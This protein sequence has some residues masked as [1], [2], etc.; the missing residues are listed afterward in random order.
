MKKLLAAALAVATMSATSAVA[1]PVFY[2][3]RAAFEAAA[4]GLAGFEGFNDVRNPAPSHAYPGFTIGETG[5]FDSV[6]TTG[7]NSFFSAA[8]TEGSGSVWY[9]DNGDSLSTFTFDAAITAFGI[10][11]AAAAGG[12]MT[13]SGFSGGS[14]GFDL[15]AE[16]PAF[17][18]VIDTTAFSSVTFD[19]EAGP[20]VGFDALA[21]GTAGVV[22][23]PAT[24]ALMI[25]GM[26]L[27]GSAL[28][29]RAL[30]SA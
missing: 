17:F 16:Q 8:T 7:A 9:D 2:T 29:R 20:E 24:W 25:G 15:A 10:D 22:P 1:A 14:F 30:A 11:V 12:L 23:E 28:R 27:I 3:D 4:G 21:F 6:V 5:G 13:V 18:G 26:G 19:M